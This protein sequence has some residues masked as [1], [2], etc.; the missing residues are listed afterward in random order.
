MRKEELPKN[1][2]LDYYRNKLLFFYW[3]FRLK[4][5]K[6]ADDA[7]ERFNRRTLEL[8]NNRPDAK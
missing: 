4:N 6:I 8:N 7:L 1:H 2:R 5:P 3:V